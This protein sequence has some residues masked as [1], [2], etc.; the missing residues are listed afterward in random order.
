MSHLFNIKSVVLI[1]LIVLLFGLMVGQML[2]V[3]FVATRKKI[4]TRTGLLPTRRFSLLTCLSPAQ[5]CA[6]PM[7]TTA[8]CYCA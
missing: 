4:A 7:Q 1:A 6:P 3:L 5:R 2:H 8:R